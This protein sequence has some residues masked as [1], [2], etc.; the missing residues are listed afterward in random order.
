MICRCT[1]KSHVH[2]LSKF[3]PMFFVFFLNWFEV[4]RIVRIILIFLDSFLEI[5]CFRF[6]LLDHFDV[7]RIVLVGFVF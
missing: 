3:A 5:C 6:F 4:L 2:F 7:F 1:F